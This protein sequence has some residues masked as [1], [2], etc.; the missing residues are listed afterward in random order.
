MPFS[1]FF[2]LR[3]PAFGVND[4]GRMHSEC[5]TAKRTMCQ[6]HSKKLSPLTFD[7]PISIQNV[8]YKPNRLSTFISAKPINQEEEK[9]NASENKT[10]FLS[11]NCCFQEHYGRLVRTGVLFV[12]HTGFP[13]RGNGSRTPGFGQ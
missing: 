8:L 11:S 12:Y 4:D 6:H 9:L 7:C 2:C 10:I 1:S 13:T 5:Q 3:C